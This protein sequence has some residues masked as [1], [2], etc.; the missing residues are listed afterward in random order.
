MGHQ[1]LRR[2]VFESSRETPTAAPRHDAI[3][4]I[5]GASVARFLPAKRRSGC[6]LFSELLMFMQNKTA[7][8][9]ITAVSGTAADGLNAV[10]AMTTKYDSTVKITSNP[11]VQRT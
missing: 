7:F 9:P 6:N 3:E 5:Y 1:A 8:A 10:A 4:A 2:G 11:N